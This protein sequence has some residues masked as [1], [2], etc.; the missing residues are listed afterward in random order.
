RPLR[1]ACS[2]RGAAACDQ[3]DGG[4]RNTERRPAR[5][6][7]KRSSH[8]HMTPVCEGIDVRLGG[9]CWGRCSRRQPASAPVTL[10]IQRVWL[11]QTIIGKGPPLENSGSGHG[12]AAPAGWH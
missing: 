1:R 7:A 8:L 11:P 6:K 12:E 2:Q 9:C 5:E 3:G 4:D 10:L